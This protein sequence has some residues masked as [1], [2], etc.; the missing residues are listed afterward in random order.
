MNDSNINNNVINL[1]GINCLF[2]DIRGKSFI[3]AFTNEFDNFNS[4]IEN[5]DNSYHLLQN[6]EIVAM[7]ITKY[8]NSFDK[9]N[10][11]DKTL[12][13]NIS[14]YD[15]HYEFSNIIALLATRLRELDQ[16]SEYGTKLYP[17]MS[18]CRNIIKNVKNELEICFKKYFETKDIQPCYNIIQKLILNITN[19]KEKFNDVI[20]EKDN[21]DNYIN[22]LSIELADKIKNV[23]N[24]YIKSRNNAIGVDNESDKVE[25]EMFFKS[26][27][28]YILSIIKQSLTKKYNNSYTTLDQ[29]KVGKEIFD[30]IYSKWNDLD[31]YTQKFYLEFMDLLKRNNDN[32]FEIVNPRD[33]QIISDS[34]DINNLQNYRINLKKD[35][36]NKPIILKIIPYIPNSIMKKIYK[37]AKDNKIISENTE[38]YSPRQYFMDIYYPLSCDNFFTL[39]EAQKLFSNNKFDIDINRVF[40]DII[41]DIIKNS[42]NSDNINTSNTVNIRGGYKAK[43]KY[44]YDFETNSIWMLRNG[45]YQKYINNSWVSYDSMKLNPNINSNVS[46]KGGN[47]NSNNNDNSNDKNLFEL[48]RWAEINKCPPFMVKKSVNGEYYCSYFSKGRKKMSNIDADHIIRRIKNPINAETNAAYFAEIFAN[49]LKHLYNNHKIEIEK[50]DVDKTFELIEEWKNN[51]EE[52]IKYTKILFKFIDLI[53]IYSDKCGNV[54]NSKLTIDNMEKYVNMCNNH[55]NY[56][57]EIN[58]KLLDEF[59]K[60]SISGKY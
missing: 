25:F 13:S 58:K 40:D 6:D 57:N 60:L 59:N 18:E 37:K 22:N 28:R 7:M 14:D 31:D 47:K 8:Y 23:M 44:C 4:I 46:Q 36:Y 15:I 38:S 32:T 10:L 16:S 53:N 21:I 39:D 19:N 51:K 49:R 34:N 52:L 9:L 24:I 35:L 30:G 11:I 48:S 17:V 41:D 56:G 27:F 45:K 20:G 29:S 12:I 2:G 42:V 33:Y 55:I 1:D 3:M 54:N 43:S 50:N 5:K 26:M